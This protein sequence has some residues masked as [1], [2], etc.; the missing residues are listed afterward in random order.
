MGGREKG[1]SR[2][3]VELEM[4]QGRKITDAESEAGWVNAAD[5]S[6]GWV[7]FTQGLSLH[8]VLFRPRKR[9]RNNNLLLI[10]IFE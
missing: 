5:K 6:V 1:W 4:R 10:C 8:L 3:E 2:E 7:I 9:K